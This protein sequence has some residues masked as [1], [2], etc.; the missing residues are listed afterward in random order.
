MGALLVPILIV[1]VTLVAGVVVLRRWSA[2]REQLGDE[3]EDP[4]TPTLAYRVPAGQ[5]PAVVLAALEGDGYVAAADPDDT[6]L[7]RVRCPA[8]LGCERARVRAVIET[9]AVTAMDTGAPIDAGPVRFED[10]R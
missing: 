10:E 3:L 9:A 4:G 2:G 7:V 5:D 6:R 8:R 1:L